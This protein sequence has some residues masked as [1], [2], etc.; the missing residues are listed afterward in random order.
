MYNLP[1]EK[2]KHHVNLNIKL[3]ASRKPKLLLKDINQEMV[4]DWLN[5][6]ESN[7]KGFELK[8][9]FPEQHFFNTDTR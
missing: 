7:Q 9:R 1:H 8:A 6:T 2:L 4:C 3:L 5:V